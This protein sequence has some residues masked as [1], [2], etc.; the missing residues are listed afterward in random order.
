MPEILTFYLMKRFSFYYFEEYG[1]EKILQIKIQF[2]K[3]LF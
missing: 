1:D 2:G 3:F